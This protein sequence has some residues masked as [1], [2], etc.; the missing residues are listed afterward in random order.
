MIGARSTN[1]KARFRR[2]GLKVVSHGSQDLRGRSFEKSSILKALA[3]SLVTLPIFFALTSV[4]DATLIVVPNSLAQTEGNLFNGFPFN[5]GNNPGM[6]RY[7]QV[8]ASSQFSALVAGGEFIT[9]IAFR[10]ES[11]S[12]GSAFSSTLPNIQINLSTTTRNPDALSTTFSTN[13]GTDDTP[14]F[15]PGPLALFSAKTGGTPKDFDILIGL[16]T[17]FFYNPAAGNLLL[18]VRNFGGGRTTQFDVQLASGDPVSRVFSPDVNASAG[19]G[20]SFGLVTRFTTTANVPEP[21]ALSL[22]SIGIATLIV[23]FRRKII[24]SRL[25]LRR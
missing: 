1:N 14:V 7:Q 10:P 20:D 3:L 12:N 2:R 8:F 17:P 6:M 19:S 4:V 22:L 16:T 9:Q 18:D 5:V 25:A 23:N 21:G 15:G 13:V 11:S 24:R